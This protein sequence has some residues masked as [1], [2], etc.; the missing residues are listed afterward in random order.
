[1]LVIIHPYPIVCITPTNRVPDT[2]EPMS[3]QHV[4]AEQQDQHRCSVLQIPVQLPNHSS[5]SQQTHNFQGTE[6]RPDT[7]QEN[8]DHQPLQLLHAPTITS[9]T[10]V[11]VMIKRVKDVVRQA[12]QQVNDEPG[13]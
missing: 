9:I 7:L 3:D 8:N 6:Q 2:G 12:T 1:M 5:Q 10:H 4:E 11:L 13:L